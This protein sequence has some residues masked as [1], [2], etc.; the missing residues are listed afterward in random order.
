MNNTPVPLPLPSWAEAATGIVNA[1]KAILKGQLNVLK[2]VTLTANAASTTVLD[3]RIGPNSV[4]ILVPITANAAAAL[5]T[6]YQTHPNTA[7]GALVLNH[8]NNAQAD[9]TFIAVLMGS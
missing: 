1:F 8:A 6:T 7:V 3:P 4:A 9:K 2:S 5:A